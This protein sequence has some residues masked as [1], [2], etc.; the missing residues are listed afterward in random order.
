MGSA[1]EDLREMVDSVETMDAEAAIRW[2]L[3]RHHPRAAFASSFGAEDTVVADILLRHRVD[4]RI[5]TLDTGRLPEE[6]HDVASR[7]RARYGATIETYFPDRISVEALIRDKGPLSFRDSVENRKECCEIRKVEP[8]RRALAGLELWI[9]GLRR[10]Q[11]VTRASLR[12]LEW[13]EAFGLLKLNPIADWNE[14]QVWDY[15]RGNDLPYNA[16]HDRGFRSIGCAPC[17]RAVAAGQ[18]VRSG[19]WWWETPEHKECGLHVRQAG[20]GT[21]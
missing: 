19:R 3:D 6:T 4:A 18:D 14:Q 20:G 8:L 17:T 10:D 15:I 12:K 1:P 13:D 9:T 21:R 5:F 16:L 11:A 7:L 2:A